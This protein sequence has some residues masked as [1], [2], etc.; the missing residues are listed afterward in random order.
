[1][2]Q[3]LPEH[4]RKDNIFCLSTSIG[5]VFLFQSL[6]QNELENWIHIINSVCAYSFSKS[7]RKETVLKEINKE[8]QLIEKNIE[9]ENKMK[10]MAELQ[11]NITPDPKSREAVNKQ[12]LQWE[13]NLEKLNV[14]LYRY[15]CYM[16]SINS[17]EAPNPKI[18]LAYASKFSKVFLTKLGAFTVCT[19]HA[20]NINKTVLNNNCKIN[21]SSNNENLFRNSSEIEFD[22]QQYLTPRSPFLEQK[23]AFVRQSKFS[24]TMKDKYMSNENL[25]IK[26]DFVFDIEKYV[27]KYFIY[28]FL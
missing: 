13:R 8:C 21:G 12:I 14:N 19:L 25:I 10:K 7:T 20:H 2:V 11:L 17:S 3:S 5:Q 28:F 4:P 15:K 16:A 18:L 1:M 9:I 24:A 22:T 26:N 27:G 23:K 6:S